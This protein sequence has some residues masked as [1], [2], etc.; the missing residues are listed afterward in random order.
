M[1]TF[2]LMNFLFP[3][4]ATKKI[5]MYYESSPW[6]IE[7]LQNIEKWHNI[8]CS[9]LTTGNHSERAYLAVRWAQLRNRLF[10][11]N[12][13]RKSDSSNFTEND[14]FSRMYYH[15][16]EHKMFE[17]IE[18]LVGI[19]RDPLTMCN[20]FHG[21]FNEGESGVQAKRWLLME[22]AGIVEDQH[23]SKTRCVFT[24]NICKRNLLFDLGA[25]T[26]SGWGGD[27]SAVGSKWFV[28]RFQSFN[29]TFDHIY[30]FEFTQKS[31][32][33]IFKDIPIN[34]LTRYSYFNVP[35]E[36]QPESVWNVWNFVKEVATEDDH[37]IVKLDID[38]PGIEHNFIDQLKTSQSLQMLVDE[39]FFEDHV[40]TIT[41][42]R[43]W[44][45]GMKRL[46]KDTYNDFLF[47]RRN[48][49]RAH[50]WP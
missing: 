4:S 22:P 38:S 5:F 3:L 6:E 31:P 10:L 45:S 21:V 46:L 41:M 8:E 28:E 18:S 44:G 12:A 34:I 35:V 16:G 9:I 48:G 17:Y 49:I 26:Y 30:A 2:I 1:M 32:S 11:V 29:M 20:G 27:T 13:E 50:S 19:I 36:S 43:Y 7:W 40:D 15:C 24:S 14:V 42:H 39:L 47:M 33:D 25:S 37:V 23:Y